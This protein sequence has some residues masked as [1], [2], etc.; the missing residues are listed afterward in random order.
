MRVILLFDTDPEM[1]D[2][3]RGH[4]EGAQTYEYISE[5]ADVFLLWRERGEK[6]KGGYLDHVF[7]QGVF[8]NVGGKIVDKIRKKLND[9]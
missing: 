5:D 8:E 3:E 1:P 9:L 2:P 4:P 6:F 7:S